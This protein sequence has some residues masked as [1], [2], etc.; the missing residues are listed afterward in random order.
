[1]A[2]NKRKSFSKVTVSRPVLTNL[3]KIP[4]KLD[5]L[6]NNLS[7]E[8]VIEI[9]QDLNTNTIDVNTEEPQ[10][11]DKV[12]KNLKDYEYKLS[13]GLLYLGE[14]INT[15][16]LEETTELEILTKQE[17]TTELEILT[18]Q[19]ETTETEVLTK[20]E[21]TTETEVLTKQEETTETEV[22]TK[23]EE[24]NKLEIAN[25]SGKIIVSEI[26]NKQDKNISNDKKNTIEL[27]EVKILNEE[28]I[29]SNN[30]SINCS[31]KYCCIL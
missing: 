31:R 21:E 22:I 16:E 19:E 25:Q 15:T 7:S 9:P 23:Q 17:E 1:M 3:D 4:S 13:Q 26:D 24:I 18:K 5:I 27:T 10:F 11:S 30:K 20:Q 12:N 29:Q 2:K 6:Q 28:T 14:N 8:K